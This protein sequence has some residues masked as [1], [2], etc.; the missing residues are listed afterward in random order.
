MYAD[1]LVLVAQ[2]KEELREKV[3]RWKECMELNG[4][5]VNIEKTKVMRSDKSGGE[6]VKTGR[7]PCAV[8]GKGVGANSIQCSDCY[9]WVHKRCSGARC[10]VVTIQ[11]FRCRIC[12]TDEEVRC[13]EERMENLNLEK[14]GQFQGV[15]KFCYL[16]D[17]LNGEGGPRLALISRVGCDW[18]KFRELSGILTSKKVALR[19]KGKVYGACVRSSM[20]YMEVKHGQ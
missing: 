20:I 8:C 12:L 11:S 19:L 1:D 6:I 7:W 16:G 13:E 5:K 15:R 4:L 10:P 17:M 9:G 18:K 2:S 3:L 14:I